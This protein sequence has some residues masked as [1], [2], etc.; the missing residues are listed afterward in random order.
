MA[1]KI[2][3]PREYYSQPGLLEESGPLIARHGKNAL[4]VTSP[5]ALAAAGPRLLP[6]LEGA[7]VRHREELFSGYVTMEK[8]RA[9]AELH[10]EADLVIG[11]GGGR[12]LDTAK[13]AG[14]L[15]EVPVVTVPTIAATC[16]AWAAVSIVYDGDGRFQRGFFNTEGPRSVLADTNL[17]LAA[18]RRYLYAGIVDSLAKWYEIA[19]Y[20]R[21]EGDSTFLQTMI[22]VAEQLRETLVQQTAPALEEWD[23]GEIGTGAVQMIDAVIF[24]AGLT[25]SLQTDTLYQGIAHPFYN[26]LSCVPASAHLL[27]GEKVGFGI[28]LQ[29]TLEKK[30][31]A[32]FTETVKEFASLENTL[33][34]A[35]LGIGEEP[36]LSFTAR[37]LWMDYYPS[38]NRLGYGFSP[39]EIRAALLETDR[40]VRRSADYRPFSA[41]AW[42]AK[43]EGKDGGR[44]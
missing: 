36:A 31:P 29:Q 26:V 22:R 27:H 7:G 17:L 6:A 35:D 3:A 9:L 41:A 4:I 40:R 43:T 8:S 10:R 30:P 5:R 44:A 19:P 14:T 12:A 37:K 21:L 20:E 15:L 28:L 24:L 32:E 23:R 18:P 39:E 42:D 11:L 2:K 38:L 13:L 25:G 33:T 1:V 16:A 34:L